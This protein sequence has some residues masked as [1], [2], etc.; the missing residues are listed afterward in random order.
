M[1][2][3]LK[4]K[5]KHCYKHELC[6]HSNLCFLGNASKI[7][8]NRPLYESRIS[9]KN[10]TYPMLHRGDSGVGDIVMLVTL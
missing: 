4:F 5:F 10:V 7:L 9:S 8:G 3:I 2:L 1:F 6:L